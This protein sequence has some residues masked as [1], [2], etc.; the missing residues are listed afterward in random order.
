[1]IRTLTAFVAAALAVAPAY[2]ADI[3]HDAEYY[4]LEAQNGDR[5]VK[6]D[7]D[8]T[9]RLADIREKHGGKPPNIIYVLLDDVGFG[10][11][12]MP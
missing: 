7:A 9:Q 3:V 10:E 5:W 1:M 11:I 6:E 4:L 8:I 12:G 2:G